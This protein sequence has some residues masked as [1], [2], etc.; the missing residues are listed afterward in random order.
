MTPL[1]Y[2]QREVEAGLIKKDPQQLAVIQLLQDIYTQ[3]V[4]QSRTGK[5]FL[6]RLTHHFQLSKPIHGLYLWGSV[7]VGK[8]FM[9]DTFYHC[10]P[11]HKMRYHFHQF[12]QYVHQELTQLQGQKNP[13]QII[14][15]KLS[16]EAKILCFDEFFVSN[17]A[18]AMLLSGLLEAIFQQGICLVTSSNIRPDDLYK[19][20]IQRE[21]FLPA[22]DLLKKY[23]TIFHMISH[24]DY[25][26][27]HVTQ[28]GV[29]F[30]PLGQQADDNM[31]KSFQHFS[32]HK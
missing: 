24:H 10:L 16:R 14:A 32:N 19:N 26:L 30:T 22:I 31:E 15:K 11:I 21:N 29:Y 1:H 17:I 9:M 23:T 18:D 28:A 8:T 20:G 2:Y 4:K 6:C 25:R 7:G 12:M 27:E 5:G 13:L 3:L